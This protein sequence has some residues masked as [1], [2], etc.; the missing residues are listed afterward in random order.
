MDE[1]SD[2]SSYVTPSQTV[3]PV[4]VAA[5]WER[6]V[7]AARLDPAPPQP[8]AGCFGDTVEL[9][10]QLIELVVNG[11]K[12]ATATALAEFEADGLPV[13]EVGDLWI[14]TDG[15]MRPR[16]VLETTEVRVG[17]LTSV[18][19]AFAWDEGEGDRTRQWWLDAHIWS[20]SRI[21]VEVGPDIPVVFERFA[22]RYQED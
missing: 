5:F 2:R 1:L 9:A 10:D 20:F 3:D 13:P 15:S 12:R 4:A 7:A 6:F 18:D 14:A 22:V 21:G 8:P 16:A 11:P 17:P 19:E